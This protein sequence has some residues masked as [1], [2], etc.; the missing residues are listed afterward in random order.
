MLRTFGLI[1][2][3]FALLG[4]FMALDRTVGHWYVPEATKG[5]LAA[6][7]AAVTDLRSGQRSLNNKVSSLDGAISSVD[8]RV[9]E[10]WETTVLMVKEPGEEEGYLILLQ[11]LPGAVQRLAEATTVLAVGDTMSASGKACVR[12]LATGE[13][14]PTDCGF[15][16]D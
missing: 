4:T 12:W 3:S 15:R 5:D 16:W 10:V 9:S 13:G 6:L 8:K 7:N 11:D 1:V 2:V 14:S